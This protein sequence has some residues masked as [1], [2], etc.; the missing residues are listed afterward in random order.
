MNSP[1]PSLQKMQTGLQKY[2]R[3]IRAGGKPKL[4]GDVLR[5]CVATCELAS[6]SSPEQLSWMSLGMNF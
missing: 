3:F 5:S 4:V 1:D 6:F 2:K